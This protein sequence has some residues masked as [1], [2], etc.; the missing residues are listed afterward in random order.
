MT[1]TRD[2]AGAAR[3]GEPSPTGRDTQNPHS[4]LTRLRVMYTG[5]EINGSVIKM[6][7]LRQARGGREKGQ[8]VRVEPVMLVIWT[9]ASG[10]YKTNTMFLLYVTS[11][12]VG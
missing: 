9:L 6:R 8:E 1:T 4:R 12:I 2:G 3:R 7:Q 10:L 5:S 11:D